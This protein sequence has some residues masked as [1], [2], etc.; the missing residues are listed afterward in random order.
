MNN[1]NLV[2]CQI[3]GYFTENHQSF[4]SHI[5]HAHHMK[6]KDYYDLYMKDESNGICKTCGNPTKFINMWKGYRQYC[7]NSCMSSSKEIQQKRKQ[8]SLIHY[9]VEFPHQSQIV[10]E[11]MAKTCLDLYGA[12]NVYASE[13]GKQK[14]K[15]TCRQR[16]G[17]DNPAQSEDIKEKTK[18]TNLQLYGTTSPFANDEVKDKIRCTCEQK[19]GVAWTSQIP[20]SRIKTRKTNLAKYGKEH[21]FQLDRVRKLTGSHAA[22]LKALRTAKANGTISSLEVYMEKLLIE[23]NIKY[24]PQYKEI[25]YPYRCDFYL[26]DYDIF[27]EIN[28]YWMH[29]GHFFDPNSEEDTGTLNIWAKKNTSQYNQAIYVWTKSDLEKRNISIKNNINYVVLWNK[30]DITNYIDSFISAHFH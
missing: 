17:V 26:P 13:Y 23:N 12:K 8:T 16:Y 14:I 6:S 18:Q 21:I 19:Y 29:G 15:E 7:C 5:T 10:K 11:S 20:E 1:E 27:I 28:G 30:Q 25:R 3:C 24:T 9:G 4:N 2:T 22:R